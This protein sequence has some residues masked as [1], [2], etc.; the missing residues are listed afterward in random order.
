MSI[1]KKSIGKVKKKSQTS[2]KEYIEDRMEQKEINV[3][4]ALLEIAQKAEEFY[5][6]H[7]GEIYATVLFEGGFQDINIDSKNFSDW[8]R[9]SWYQLFNKDLNKNVIDEGINT[10]RATLRFNNKLPIKSLNTRIAGNL[11]E[12]YIDLCNKQRDVVQITPGNWTILRNTEMKFL[13]GKSMQ[14]LPI[15]VKGN[16]IELLKKYV[17]CKGTD[18]ILFVAFI[19]GCYMPAGPFPILIIQGLQGSGKSLHSRI[20]KRLTDPTRNEVMTFPRNEREIYIVANKSRVLA[21]DNISELN[22]NLADTLCK[23]ATGSSFVAKKNYT[24]SE[25]HVI[26]A[27]NPLILNGID[28]IAKRSDLADRSIIINLPKI[29]GAKRRSEQEFWSSFEEDRPYILAG[30]FDLISEILKNYSS[31]KLSTSPRMRDF[32]KW[33]TACEH[34]LGLKKGGFSAIYSYNQKEAYRD[35]L[36]QSS[37]ATVIEKYLRINKSFK[38]TATTLVKELKKQAFKEN[39]EFDIKPNKI[40][41]QLS[42]IEAILNANGIEYNYDRQKERIHQLWLT[43]QK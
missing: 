36:E 6:T 12:L 11:K 23:I 20:I 42:R 37:L 38:G 3:T 40:K 32:T 9:G 17:T 10:L 2:Q 5:Q 33:I 14:E 27:C 39:I 24:D 19:L 1:N 4:Q 16:N 29:I 41:D 13:R 34:L 7:D 30:I 21:F 28:T 26:E 18:W 35:A 8:I 43:A 22:N 31:F 15:P 25:E